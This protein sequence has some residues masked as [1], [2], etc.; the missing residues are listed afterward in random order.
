MIEHIKSLKDKKIIVVE[1][2]KLLGGLLSK[3]LINEGCNVRYIESGPPVLAS[4]EA[5]KPDLILL[6]LLLPGISGFGVLDSLKKNVMTKD[7]PVIII[8][9]LGEESDIEKGF[10]L[11]AASYL[12]KATVTV[13]GIIKEV[14]RILQQAKE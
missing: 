9:C 14:S 3:I 11:G 2:D 5:E 7:V 4:A 6:D 12:I 8:S 13:D 1:D 10:S